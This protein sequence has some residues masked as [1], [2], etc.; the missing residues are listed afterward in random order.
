[1]RFARRLV[2]ADVQPLPWHESSGWALVGA[3]LV[4][5]CIHRA[6]RIQDFFYSPRSNARILLFDIGFFFLGAALATAFIL[7]PTSRREAI[8]AGASW[9][10]VI[11][12][13]LTRYSRGR[14]PPHKVAEAAASG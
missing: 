7:E 11:S 3:I 1:M 8:L 13:L 14:G 9:E 12:G 10:G 2:D 6:D 5:F 4:Y